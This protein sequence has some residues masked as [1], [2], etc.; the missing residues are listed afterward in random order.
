VCGSRLWPTP[1]GK[2]KDLPEPASRSFL[3]SSFFIW[4]DRMNIETLSDEPG[5]FLVLQDL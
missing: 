4:N 3:L 1:G 5:S 2:Q